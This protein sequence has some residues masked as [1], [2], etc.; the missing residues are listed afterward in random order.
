MKN[1]LLITALMAGATFTTDAFSIQV[2]TG[3]SLSS[4]S[5]ENLTDNGDGTYSVSKGTVEE[6]TG[7]IQ[8]GTFY[9]T[10]SGSNGYR[11]TYN[12]KGLPT[13]KIDPSTGAATTYTYNSDNTMTEERSTGQRIVTTF[14]KNIDS[15]EIISKASYSNPNVLSEVNFGTNGSVSKM[16]R[17]FDEG[18]NVTGSAMAEYTNS[19]GYVELG[20]AF[21]EFNSDGTVKSSR[22]TRFGNLF[23]YNYDDTTG[24][25]V[26]K[27]KYDTIVETYD[28]ADGKLKVCDANGE[29][30][31]VTAYNTLRDYLLAPY[32]DSA[33]LDILDSDF[34]T[35]GYIP[36]R[37]KV[38]SGSENGEGISSGTNSLFSGERGKRIYTVQQANEVAGKKNK[39]MIRYK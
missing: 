26:S 9:V 14:N 39:V 24:K 19:G 15:V 36:S 13:K 12:E 16:M 33:Y 35:V 5:D 7:Y 3:K 11:Y 1:T 10:Q 25:P 4:I 6:Q 27:V 8:N 38:N 29:N 28:F 21:I 18:G 23:T 2:V 17:I 34:G 30:C 20:E 22:S 31:E 32:S 37:L